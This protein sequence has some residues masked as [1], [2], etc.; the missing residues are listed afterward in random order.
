MSA[1]TRARTRTRVHCAHPSDP[2]FSFWSSVLPIGATRG[3]LHSPREAKSI[4]CLLRLSPHPGETR[5]VCGPRETP[6][7][8]TPAREDRMRRCGQITSLCCSSRPF[9]FAEGTAALGN[10]AP[11]PRSCV[12]PENITH[13]SPPRPSPAGR[14]R[15]P[16]HPGEGHPLPIPACGSGPGVGGAGSWSPAPA[17]A[18]APQPATLQ[19][20]AHAPPL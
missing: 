17:P 7:G 3:F 16:A 15:V 19:T 14:Y 1:H 12:W 9:V 6:G 5:E 20:P 11:T 2:R 13:L 18:P 10:L 4:P 8:R